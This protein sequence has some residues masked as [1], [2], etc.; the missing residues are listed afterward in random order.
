MYAR[1][2]VCVLLRYVMLLCTTRDAVRCGGS[3]EDVLVL[4]SARGHT[5]RHRGHIR[6]DGVDA[7]AHGAATEDESRPLRATEPTTRGGRCATR[8]HHVGGEGDRRGRGRGITVRGLRVASA[9]TSPC[10]GGGGMRRK[11]RVLPGGRG[12]GR[13]LQ[14]N[15]LLVEVLQHLANGREWQVLH[16]ALPIRAQR[17]SQV[18]HATHIR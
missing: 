2:C 5:G 13:V 16:L 1:A 8:I 11:S 15:R 6:A 17:H 18:L 4:H 3:H 10:G 7:G 14:G 12:G 9:S